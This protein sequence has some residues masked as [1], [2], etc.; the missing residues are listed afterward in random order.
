MQCG[1]RFSE[2][3]PAS[4]HVNRTYGDDYFQGGGTSYH[5]YLADE[6][7]LRE[8]GRW[9]GRLLC[10][11]T[12]PGAVLDV[13]AA[14]GFWLAGM[15]DLGWAGHGLEPNDAMAAH[16]RERLGL[17]IRPGTLETFRDDESFDLVAMIQVVAHFVDVRRALSVA[18]DRTRPGGHWLIETWDRSSLTAR[19]FG[20]RWHEYSPPSVLHWFSRD[21]LRRFAKSFGMREVA[22]GRP[23][24]RISGAHARSLV[25]YKLRGS[26]LGGVAGIALRAIPDGAAIPYPAEDLFWMLLRKEPP[27]R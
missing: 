4:D 25:A 12:P 11:Y 15:V 8:R 23:R 20:R 26:R 7:I 3:L 21:G 9:Y 2:H 27:T 24:K 6:E 5:D 17:D 14:S 22:W 10:R 13:G 1:H 16:A 19:M 18:A